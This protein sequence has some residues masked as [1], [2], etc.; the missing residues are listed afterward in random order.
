MSRFYSTLAC[1]LA[2]VGPFALAAADEPAPTSGLWTKMMPRFKA[3]D[4]LESDGMVIAVAVTRPLLRIVVQ[5]QWKDSQPQYQATLID[6]QQFFDTFQHE[7]A[8]GNRDSDSI[9]QRI[10]RDALHADT[11]SCP[12][13]DASYRKTGLALASLAKR[14]A[15]EMVEPKRSTRILLLTDWHVLLRSSEQEIAINTSNA[16]PLAV[17][18]D[19]LK[20]QILACAHR[21]KQL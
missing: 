4:A 21:T 15:E 8:S 9:W 6:N 17:A 2:L 20:T 11:Q 13:L 18:I 12:E 5:R 16:G 3:T 7:Y 14:E 10:E 1:C 19:E